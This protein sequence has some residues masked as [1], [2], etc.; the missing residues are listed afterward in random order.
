MVFFQF[1]DL[2]LKVLF[3][4]EA[5]FKTITVGIS[6][7]IDSIFSEN[8][9][10]HLQGKEVPFL[11]CHSEYLRQKVEEI[12]DFEWSKVSLGKLLENTCYPK[13]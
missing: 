9:S 5:A 1:S 6:N 7:P 11:Y 8:T 3:S 4:K 2:A 10:E 12:D 13:S